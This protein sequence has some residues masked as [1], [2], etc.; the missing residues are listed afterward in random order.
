MPRDPTELKR[1]YRQALLRRADQLRA[2]RPAVAGGDPDALDAARTVG[3]ALRGSGATFGFAEVSAIATLLETSPDLDVLRR[4]EGLVVELLALGAEERAE[5]PYAAEWLLAAAG[6]PADGDTLGRAVDLRGA[7]SAVA[8]ACRCTEAALADRVADYLGLEVADV[9]KRSAR[10]GRLVPEALMAA[11]RIVPLAE[12]DASIRV[13]TSEPTALPMELRLR[14][15]TGRHADF[16]VAPPAEIDAALTAD[17]GA[18]PAAARAMRT[19]L[20]QPELGERRVLVV[21]D[22]PTSRLL[23]RALLERKGYQVVE[24]RDGVS[25]LDVMRDDRRVA[26]VVADLNMPEMDGL[27]LLWEI[28]AEPTLESLPVIVVTGETDGSIEMQL[29]EEGA[30]D[31]IRKPI[32]PRLFLARVEATIRRLDG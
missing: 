3:Q 9:A 18:R 27:E 12:D 15:V 17:L 14:A 19:A 2:L 4:L 22:D 29:L 1:W 32:D 31:Y 20:E 8:L 7:W 11:G 26:L 23:A 30:D 24:A 16:A 10:A 6:L 25:A 21:D 13:A 28:R 5:R